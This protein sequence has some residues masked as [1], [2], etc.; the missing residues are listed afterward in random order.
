MSWHFSQA[1]VEAY[2][3]DNSLDGKLFVPL[4]SSDMPE[5]YCWRDRTTECLDLFQFGMTLEPSTANLGEDM[6]T[7]F[8]E[9][10]HVKT[11]H[12]QEKEPE[13]TATAQD[14]GMRC[15]GL[16]ERCNRALCQLKTAHCLHLV[17]LK[18]FSGTWP[19]WGMMLDGE[20]SALT[21]PEH[22]TKGTESGLWPTPVICGNYQA[23]KPGTSRGTGLATAVKK[24]PTPKSR[25]YKSGKGIAGLKRNTPDLNVV[26]ANLDQCGGESTQQTYPTPT[27]S[28]M[29]YA[30]MEQARFSGN[31]K[32]RPKYQ[33]VKY[34][35]L[36]RSDGMGGPGNSG[37]QGGENLRTNIGG[38]LNPGWV[39]W[40]MGW[41]IGWTDLKPLEMDR[42]QQWKR[43]HGRY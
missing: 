24:Y 12:A 40:L 20:C 39:E 28:M 30:D 43:L 7:W 42:F 29:T 27:R 35:T 15:Q 23:P 16:L 10:F 8:R 41:P 37:R 33:D 5:T 22:L 13:S 25:D 6:L 3:E 17:D 11:Y 34:P 19:R 9:V 36:T 1:L 18:S 2:L 31:D 38:Q 21:M 4:K 14:S 26:V 32:R